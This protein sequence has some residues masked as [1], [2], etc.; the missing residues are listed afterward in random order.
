MQRTQWKS[1]EN[2]NVN[3]SFDEAKINDIDH[4]INNLDRFVRV[5]KP[6]DED[7]ES[8]DHQLD[9]VTNF[10][11]SLTRL[12]TSISSDKR[13]DRH[14]TTLAK[15]NRAFVNLG[16]YTSTETDMVYWI[17]ENLLSITACGKDWRTLVLRYDPVTDRFSPDYL[18][19][20]S[21]TRNSRFLN[22]HW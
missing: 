6:A 15:I 1:F 11:K 21:T 8:F 20:S 9:L 19:S 14:L 13:T 4:K 3:L 2:F 12:I 22:L 10:S 5:N 18:T 7:D 17:D 16:G